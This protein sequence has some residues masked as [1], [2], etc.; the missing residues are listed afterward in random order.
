MSWQRA[1][2]KYTRYALEVIEDA[3]RSS[4]DAVVRQD[5]VGDNNLSHSL[6]LR[7]P[8]IFMLHLERLAY[9]SPHLHESHLCMQDTESPAYNE[10]LGLGPLK[11]IGG[12]AATSRV[13]PPRGFAALPGPTLRFSFGR[14]CANAAKLAG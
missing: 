1:C 2:V 4:S 11:I 5:V 8:A 10:A 13:S 9:I 3:D 7:H 12:S 14:E 6:Q